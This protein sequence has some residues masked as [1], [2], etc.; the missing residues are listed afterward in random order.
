LRKRFL[1]LFLL[2]TVVLLSY[3]HIVVSGHSGDVLSAWTATPPTI[4]GVM[5]TGEWDAAA[6]AEFTIVHN[7][8]T[9]YVMNDANNLYIAIKIQDDD[10]YSDRVSIIFD[11]DHSGGSLAVNDDCF[12]VDD[13]GLS[14]LYYDG[15]TGYHEWDDVEHGSGDATIDGANT[16]YFEAS[17]P[18]CSGDAQDFRL[19]IGDT[20]GFTVWY[21]DRTNSV[22]YS[23]G[24]PAWWDSP[25]GFGDIVIA[26]S[27]APSLIFGL[28]PIMF[29]ALVG[30]LVAVVVVVVF[31]M[32][33]RRPKPPLR[34]AAPPTAF[35][36]YCGVA[37][38]PEAVFCPNRGRKTR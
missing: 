16:W 12:R 30:G 14:D 18:L 7:P 1:A 26:S 6:S 22:S 5:A 17:H 25:D 13:R 15:A 10:A 35:C 8:A 3:Y 37:L 19:S 4:D 36:P 24:W 29:Y 32:M 38:K 27:P 28:E 33:R 9:I 2:V 23:N 20:V 31:L 11:N 21:W 34:P